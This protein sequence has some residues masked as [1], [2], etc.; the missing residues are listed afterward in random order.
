[1]LEEIKKLVEF[2]DRRIKVIV[3]TMISSGIRVG[4]W[5]FL[6]WK[7]VIPIRRDDK[8]NEFVTAKLVVYGGEKEEYYF[9]YYNKVYNAIKEC[10]DFRTS[11]GERITGESWIFRDMWQKTFIRYSHN[12]G[13]LIIVTFTVLTFII[14]LVLCNREFLKDTF[15]GSNN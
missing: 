3:L 10:M 6:K 9:F 8:D 2:D 4:A 11:F 7:N 1:M 13:V 5:Y 14:L 15:L 12:I